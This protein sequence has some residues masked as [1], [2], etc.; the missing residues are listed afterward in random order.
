MYEIPAEAQPEFDQEKSL[1][2]IRISINDDVDEQSDNSEI[3]SLKR[4][5]RESKRQC[6]EY[7]PNRDSVM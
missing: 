4:T 1:W 3:G 2:T 5:D 6:K 7:F